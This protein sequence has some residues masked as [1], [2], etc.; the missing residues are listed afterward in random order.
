MKTIKRVG[1]GGLLLLLIN[2]LSVSAYELNTADESKQY[3]EY[4]Y[5]S[6]ENQNADESKEADDESTE[7]KEEEYT[8]DYG[9]QYE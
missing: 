6:S 9:S 3:D 4:S 7:P 1:L 5:E 2:T 8:D